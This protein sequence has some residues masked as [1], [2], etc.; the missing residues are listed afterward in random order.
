MHAVGDGVSQYIIPLE[1]RNFVAFGGDVEQ[2]RDCY[3]DFINFCP[4]SFPVEAIATGNTLRE[5]DILTYANGED[6][7]ASNG[8]IKLYAKLSPKFATS[9]TVRFSSDVP[10]FATANG[11]ALFA[12]QE[13][14][15]V[16]SYA[17]IRQ[18][19]LKLVVK[20]GAMTEIVSANAIGFARYDSLEIYVAVGNG[21]DSVAKYRVNG[22][23]WINLT[24]ATI[25]N[26]PD[27]GSNPIYFLSAPFNGVSASDRYG[28][29]SW[30]HRLTLHDNHAPSGI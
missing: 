22:G 8:Q 14:G 18:S 9:E 27:P 2:T 13:T 30:L 29:P 17:Y 11:Y 5:P 3:L 6:L 21:V 10:N 20:I 26:E 19:D 7:I 12:Y 4:G 1:G 15:P 16:N 23:S 25:A 28:W 24:L